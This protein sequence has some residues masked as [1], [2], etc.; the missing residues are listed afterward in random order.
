MLRWDTKNAVKRRGLVKKEL[1]CCI[2]MMFLASPGQGQVTTSSGSIAGIVQDEDGKPLPH[3]LVTW[4]RSVIRPEDSQPP[5]GSVLS[6]EKGQFAFLGLGPATYLLCNRSSPSRS[7]VGNCAWTRT[8]P[9]VVLQDGTNV[10]GLKLTAYQGVRVEIEFQDK[11]K[12]LKGPEEADRTTALQ[13]GV[14]TRDGMFHP[15]A[16]EGRSAEAQHYVLVVPANLPVRL[17]VDAFGL[18]LKDDKDADL[19]A[20]AIGDEL[21]LTAGDGP[22]KYRFKVD[23]KGGK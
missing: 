19:G 16:I 4:Y 9:A 11:K 15:A 17:Q 6:D 18:E 22:K 13:A 10:V 3:V 20:A 2:A 5:E 8:P 21:T 1:L 14:L 12:V 7:L 23:K